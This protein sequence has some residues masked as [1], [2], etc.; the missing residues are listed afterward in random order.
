[1]V[2]MK[3]S[4]VRDFRMLLGLGV[5]ALVCAAQAEE[6]LAPADDAVFAD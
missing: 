1:M 5:C 3:T 6:T 2:I 4:P